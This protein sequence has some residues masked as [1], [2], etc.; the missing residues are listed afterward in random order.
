MTSLCP[1]SVPFIHLQSSVSDNF[2]PLQVC[3]LVRLIHEA[4]D[5]AADSS[6]KSQ[7]SD[8]S[9]LAWLGLSECAALV[10]CQFV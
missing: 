4:K 5:T 10:V 6:R 7:D 9:F 1:C 8:K 3:E 2:P